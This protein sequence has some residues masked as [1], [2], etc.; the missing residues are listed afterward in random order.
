M[1]IQRVLPVATAIL[2]TAAGIAE[3]S[4]SRLA[5]HTDHHYPHAPYRKVP[6]TVIGSSHSVSPFSSLNEPSYD[7]P[8]YNSPSS[9]S[10]STVDDEP[11]DSPP[12]P[13]W[14]KFDQDPK[15]KKTN[16]PLSYRKQDDLDLM[17]APAPDSSTSFLSNR[18]D[19]SASLSKNS[20]TLKP[21]RDELGL[22]DSIFGRGTQ[23]RILDSIYRWFEA[24]VRANPG[25]V[26]RFVCETYRT[27]ESMDGVAYL[28]MKVTN[29]A[30]AYTISEVFDQSVDINDITTAARLGRTASTCDEM[31]CELV[32][33]QL[34]AVGDYLDGFDDFFLSLPGIILG[35]F[36][37]IGK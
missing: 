31:Q 4:P 34:R 37:T 10:A 18:I 5:L 20:L 21:K 6:T 24:R 9:V 29:N 14:L 17:H 16:K 2:A 36:S 3:E 33:A 35:A 13:A 22:M 32:D 1:M 30:V 19:E 12:R 25:C 23:S 8:S 27:G 26:R 28:L 15:E 7:A 11:A